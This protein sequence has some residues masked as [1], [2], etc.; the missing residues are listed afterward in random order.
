MPSI[1]LLLCSWKAL[2]RASS[3]RT[4]PFS[5]V[6]TSRS[7]ISKT[8]TT[9][10]TTVS[11]KSEE[12]VDRRRV[13]RLPAPLKSRA[14]RCSSRSISMKKRSVAKSGTSTVAIWY[15]SANLRLTV[16]IIACASPITPTAARRRSRP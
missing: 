16:L 4:K 7:A 9:L 15:S 10:S 1:R 11:K 5:H 3:G 2:S 14:Q 6:R 12:S 8:W 13:R